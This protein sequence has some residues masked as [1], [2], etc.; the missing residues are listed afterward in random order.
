MC[1][2]HRLLCPA[3]AATA[4]VGQGG[5]QRPGR[6]LCAAAERQGGR[7]RVAARRPRRRRRP[8]LHRAQA[9]TGAPCSQ[10]AR[11]LS[12]CLPPAA[13][14]SSTADPC[15]GSRVTAP[16][17]FPSRRPCC[18]AAAARS[19]AGGALR[20][21]GAGG[22]AGAQIPALQAEP[23][24]HR[25]A[26]VRLAP[27]WGSSILRGTARVVPTL[28][29]PSSLPSSSSAATPQCPSASS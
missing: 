28:T 23:L 29:T 7:G 14:P 22:T 16:P 26:A 18:A 12:A 8:A 13:S 27:G 21:A 6:Q 4:G 2:A 19:A 1:F 17:P 3:A 20:R 15:S 9:A 11:I 10:T 5:A 24:G 25:C